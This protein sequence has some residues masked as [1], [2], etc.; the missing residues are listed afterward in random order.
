MLL[1]YPPRP[2]FVDVLDPRPVKRDPRSRDRPRVGRLFAAPA[3]GTQS[4]LGGNLRDDGFDPLEVRHHERAGLVAEAIEIELTR[5][6][7]YRPACCCEAVCGNRGAV[8]ASVDD[9]EVGAPI[10]PY[11]R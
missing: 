4:K 11:P 2:A 3:V 7:R 8:A 6:P 9:V 5:H 1:E 10:G